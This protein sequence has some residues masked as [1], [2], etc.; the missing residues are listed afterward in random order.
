M[1]E[2]VSK[3]L[4]SHIRSQ[5]AFREGDYVEALEN[6]FMA[7]DAVL[8]KGTSLSRNPSVKSDLNRQ[9]ILSMAGMYRDGCSHR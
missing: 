2:Y 5:Q 7:I 1:A 4:H 8:M 9:R 3:H 6:G